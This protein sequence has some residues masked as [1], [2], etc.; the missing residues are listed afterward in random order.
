MNVVV[1]N[2][3]F[4]R[5]DIMINLLDPMFEQ[6]TFEWI[7]ILKE[8]YI[9]DDCITEFITAC[10]VDINVAKKIYEEHGN[11]VLVLFELACRVCCEFGNLDTLIWLHELDFHENLDIHYDISL[12]KACESNSYDIIDW[13][14]DKKINDIVTV[15]NQAIK[16]SNLHIVQYM[17]NVN[18]WEDSINVLLDS[19]NGSFTL[20]CCYGRIDIAKWLYEIIHDRVSKALIDVCIKY[21]CNNDH[22]TLTKWLINL[23]K[24]STEK[25]DRYYNKVLLHGCQVSCVD[26]IK[27]V[28]EN[29]TPNSK[30]LY[31]GFK[32]SDMLEIRMLLFDKMKFIRDVHHRGIFR[33]AFYHACRSN[34]YRTI[35][36]MC[37]N[38]ITTPR[39]KKPESVF[40]SKLDYV[41][42]FIISC[43]KGYLDTAKKM[44]N[45]SYLLDILKLYKKGTAISESFLRS[46]LENKLNVAKWLYTLK[47]F[48]SKDFNWY[49]VFY[50]VCLSNI[51]HPNN[52]ELVRWMYSLKEMKNVNIRSYNDELF[53]IMCDGKLHDI[54]KFL[55]TVCKDYVIKLE[56]DRFYFTI[57]SM[58]EK[59]ARG[60]IKKRKRTICQKLFDK[61]ICEM[62]NKT[63]KQRLKICKFNHNYCRDCFLTHCSE[64]CLKCFNTITEEHVVQ[65]T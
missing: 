40:I 55:T 37:L 38:M 11:K 63:C 14:S 43:Y 34:D 26:T 4:V 30:T 27:W 25:L 20:A 2:K 54:A 45:V 22:V 64:Y 6:S 39:I 28:L 12:L 8:T 44:Y 23:N 57:V 13:L 21:S 9:L 1:L 3:H 41:K 49:D 10:S 17:Y 18:G 24:H 65:Y 15:F 51:K 62:C 29:H 31:K 46:C 5:T 19:L 35:N 32:N 58:Y 61:H 52:L 59:I 42:G 7:D 60:L 16:Y 36:W 50:E 33:K 47:E 53:V 56:S 48:K